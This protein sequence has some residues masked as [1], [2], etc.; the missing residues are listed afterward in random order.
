MAIWMSS[1][2]L[3]SERTIA[4][5]MAK[6]KSQPYGG[7]PTSSLYTE[8][9]L[10]ADSNLLDETANNHDMTADSGTPAY[11]SGKFVDAF[12]F[13]NNF[14][15]TTVGSNYVFDCFNAGTTYQIDCWIYN[16]SRANNT[17]HN[18]APTMMG[19]GVSY[20]TIGHAWGIGPNSSG[21]LR[22]QSWRNGQGYYERVDSTVAI[23]LNTWVHCAV[24][25]THSGGTTF[26]KMFQDGAL[27]ADTS[28]PFNSTLTNPALPFD[29][30]MYNSVGW[31]GYID[32]VRILIDDPTQWTAAFTPPTQKYVVT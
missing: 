31:Q 2:R 20:D 4:T 1:N 10:H 19:G 26:V 6:T 13:T 11:T 7:L 3:G 29:M 25:L 12:D 18:D 23:P 8:I 15:L 14:H 28:F 16:T 17:D 5:E 32:E 22:F 9:L 27:T 21:F 24:A 30:G